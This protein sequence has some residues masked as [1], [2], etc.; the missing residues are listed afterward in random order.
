MMAAAQVSIGTLGVI[1]T[2][3]LQTVSAYNLKE[4]LWRDDFEACLERHDAGGEQIAISVS[5][6]VLS[7]SPGISTACPTSP[8]SLRSSGSTTFAR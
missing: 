3:T 1:S 4:R 2:I 5:S 6:G 7:P 8:L